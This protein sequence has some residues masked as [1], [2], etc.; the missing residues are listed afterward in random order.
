[1]ISFDAALLTLSSEEDGRPH[2]IGNRCKACG[3]CFFP[4]QA[5]CTSCFQEGTLQEKALDSKGT[6]YAYTIVERASLAPPGFQVPYAYGY[7]DL[8]EG[9]RVL[10]KISDWSAETLKIGTPVELVLEPVGHDVSG[11]KVMGFCFRII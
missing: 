11:K 1:M 3:A 8:P 2:L 6:V 7:I 5:L 10:A 9:V 4:Q